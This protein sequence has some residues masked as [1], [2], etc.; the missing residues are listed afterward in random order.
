M[1]STF[2]ILW[3]SAAADRDDRGWKP[4]PQERNSITDRMALTCFQ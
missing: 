2:S 4:L 3:E 1:K